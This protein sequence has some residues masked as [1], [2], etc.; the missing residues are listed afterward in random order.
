MPLLTVT[1]EKLGTTQA[2]FDA[3]V[4]TAKEEFQTDKV[5]V[6]ASQL[7]MTSAKDITQETE[8]QLLPLT[9]VKLWAYM[10]ARHELGIYMRQDPDG[11]RAWRIS[12]CGNK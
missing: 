7:T 11:K 6:V 3:M 9:D 12:V 10:V 1:P 4:A 5:S 2:D 8:E